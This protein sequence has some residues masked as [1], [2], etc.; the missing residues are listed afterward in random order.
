MLSETKWVRLNAVDVLPPATATLEEI[1]VWQMRRAIR[2]HDTY[3]EAAEALGISRKGLW[4]LRDRYN[5][6]TTPGDDE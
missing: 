1:R 5:I 4:E 2:A 3:A 6:D